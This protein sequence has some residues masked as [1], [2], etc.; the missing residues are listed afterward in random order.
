MIFGVFGVHTSMESD[1]VDEMRAKKKHDKTIFKCLQKLLEIDG[2]NAELDSRI[3]GLASLP[4][5]MGGLGLRSAARIAPAAYWAAWADA[6]PMIK[7]RLPQYAGEW[8]AMLSEAELLYEND[9]SAKVSGMP[10]CLAEVEEARRLLKQEG[11]G[12]PESE[13]ACPSWTDLETGTRPPQPHNNEPGE[14]AHGWQ[15][16]ASRVRDIKYRDFELIPHLPKRAQAMVLSQG[17]RYAGKFLQTMPFSPQV[18]IP[19]PNFQCL[20]RRRLQLDL[21]TQ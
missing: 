13:C 5:M 17:G 4:A 9:P 11:L 15:F 12:S 19:A 1:L 20:L 18:E 3:K 14:W 6:L 16:F 21:N 8:I 2:T 7:S 10:S